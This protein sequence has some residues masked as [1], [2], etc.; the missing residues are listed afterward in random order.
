MNPAMIII[1]GLAAI[2]GWF[3]AAR[4]FSPT[5]KVVKDVIDEAV[6]EMTKED[7]DETVEE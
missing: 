6:Y 2:A 3:L 7:E 1:I 5:G 4:F